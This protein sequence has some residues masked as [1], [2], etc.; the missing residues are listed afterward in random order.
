VIISH[1]DADHF[2]GLPELARQFS[3][4]RLVISQ[5]MAAQRARP[6]IAALLQLLESRGLELQTVSTGDELTLAGDVRIDVLNP[7]P[8]GNGQTDNADSI[9]LDV[10]YGGRRFLLPGDLEAEGLDSLLRRSAVTYDVVMAPHHGSS[11][12]RPHDFLT[13]ANPGY[14]V[15]SSRRGNNETL[16]T[17]LLTTR[18]D[19]ATFLHTGRDGAIRLVIDHAGQLSVDAWRSARW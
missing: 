3:M 5:R 9:V 14:V 10:G 15:V 18:P 13:W 6:V 1:A 19:P 11:G 4:D 2:N 12:S 16:L 8:S 7:P 17:Q